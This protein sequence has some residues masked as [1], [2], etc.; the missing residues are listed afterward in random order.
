MNCRFFDYD[1][2]FFLLPKVKKRKKILK[3]RLFSCQ[4]SLDCG[5]R[6]VILRHQKVLLKT[7]HWIPI[8]LSVLFVC[9]LNDFLKIAFFC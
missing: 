9:V 4:T 3:I 6:V 7:F 1:L 5:V 2:N 8:L